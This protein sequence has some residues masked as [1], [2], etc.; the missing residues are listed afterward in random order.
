MYPV[1]CHFSKNSLPLIM[2][3]FSFF[4]LQKWST[5]VIPTY[6]LR[7]QCFPFKI[8]WECTLPKYRHA[9]FALFYCFSNLES[10]YMRIFIVKSKTT[11]KAILFSFHWINRTTLIIS[12]PI[13]V[14]VFKLD[15]FISEISFVFF[16]SCIVPACSKSHGKGVRP[17]LVTIS[18]AFQWRKLY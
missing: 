5:V 4:L 1:Q 9:F 14:A 3:N 13:V 12:K 16:S 2:I 18:I 8:I 6:V 7:D 10:I 15:R 17:N 11:T